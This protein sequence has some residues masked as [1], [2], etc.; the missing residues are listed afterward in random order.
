MKLAIYIII[1]IF[2]LAIL[3]VIIFRKQ[4]QEYFELRAKKRELEEQ[5]KAKEEAKIL[6]EKADKQEVLLADLKR[7][8]DA[9]KR[10]ETVDSFKE[11]AKPKGAGFIGTLDKIS[12]FAEKL[13]IAQPP[14]GKPKGML[15]PG[16]F[17]DFGKKPKKNK[18]KKS[19]F[20]INLV[21]F[22]IS[23]ALI[24]LIRFIFGGK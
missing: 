9:R 21:F 16:M 17:K 19:Q 8:A 15:D 20:E 6:E 2:A 12:K 1:I 22:M 5:I 23:G 3:A 13:P 24:S 18:N 11:K 14:K 10:I 4:L 7:Q